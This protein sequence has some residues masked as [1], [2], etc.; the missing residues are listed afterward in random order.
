MENHTR[1]DVI[2]YTVIRSNFSKV[3]S[4]KKKTRE[5]YKK[6]K[7]KRSLELEKSLECG[8]SHKR[9]ERLTGRTGLYTWVCL[10]IYVYMWMLMWVMCQSLRNPSTCVFSRP[11]Q[12]SHF[13]IFSA[14][15]HRT[16]PGI[17]IQ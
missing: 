14:A 11:F 17:D 2:A 7:K 1:S 10:H 12:S 15:K 8:I 3:G 4:Q 9:Q 16:L 6:K 5:V 13:P